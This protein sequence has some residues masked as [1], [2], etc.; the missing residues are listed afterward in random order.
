[1]N[2]IVS[3]LERS[4]TSLL[5]Q[6]LEAGGAP[7]AYDKS[8]EPDA[9]NPRGYFEL[10]GGRIIN[11]VMKGTFKFDRYSD[12][13]IKI[14]AFGLKHLP[15]GDYKII[16][17]TRNLDEIVDSQHKMYESKVPL[18]RE[19]TKE[20]LDKLLSKTKKELKNRKDVK[21]LYVNYNR[22]INQPDVQLKSIKRFLGDFDIEKAKRVIDTNLYRSR[23]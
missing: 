22:L 19:D 7:V 23:S 1:M 8:R 17:M 13:F 21:I 10:E 3:G 9:H 18:S 14:T 2:Y 5:M 6:V 12:K 4:G 11:K 16:F 15:E 20:L